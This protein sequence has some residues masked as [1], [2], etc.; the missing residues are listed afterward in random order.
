MFSPSHLLAMSRDPDVR[1][2]HRRRRRAR[3]E[4]SEGGG[5]A[6]DGLRVHATPA[7]APD[8][9]PY[10]GSPHGSDHLY[11]DS[12]PRRRRRRGSRR[13]R[14]GGDGEDGEEEEEDSEDAEPVPLEEDEM[15]AP[16]PPPFEGSDAETPADS[17]EDRAAQME[18]LAEGLGTRMDAPV[19]PP[20]TPSDP[21]LGPDDG[22]AE[23]DLDYWGGVDGNPRHCWLCRYVDTRATDVESGAIRALTDVLR[24]F[25]GRETRRPL[26]DRLARSF[27]ELVYRQQRPRATRAQRAALEP[28]MRAA[29]Y[30]CLSEHR[31][32]DVLFLTEN[33]WA[34]EVLCRAAMD[35]VRRRSASG[36]VMVNEKS[37]RAYTQLVTLRMKLAAAARARAS[38]EGG[39]DDVP[40]AAHNLF[41]FGALRPTANRERARAENAQ[42]AFAA[43][44]APH[45]GGQRRIVV[46]RG[47]RLRTE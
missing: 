33:I 28:R 43:A 20:S 7:P 40:T 30:H 32:M 19:D 4:F 11:D 41:A 14:G 31:V 2:Q 13:R 25:G 37:V 36:V 24:E 17:D 6:D 8:S 9:D 39:G 47:G 27:M 12:P 26:S 46:D 21:D 34:T 45:D 5:S 35:S 22:G 44:A 1:A 18:A 3:D 38:E 16:R 10:V 29:F 42:D 15:P 23:E